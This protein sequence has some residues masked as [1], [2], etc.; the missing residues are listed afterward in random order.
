MADAMIP[1]ELVRDLEELKERGHVYEVV[2]DSGRIYIV[3]RGYPLPSGIYNLERTD[4]LIFTTPHYP[5]AGFD[6][7]WVDANIA[8]KNGGPPKNAESIENHL[9]RQWRR[10]SY[11]PY[12]VRAWNPSE[13]NVVSFM[14]YVDQRLK[15]G[16]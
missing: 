2:E 6:M 12:N 14:A 9:G 7:F 1:E 8:L 4:L 5:N 13:D 10:F 15:R 3:F 16:D 11:H